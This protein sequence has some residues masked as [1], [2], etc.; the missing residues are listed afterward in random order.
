VPTDSVEL[1]ATYLFLQARQAHHAPIWLSTSSDGGLAW[2]RNGGSAPHHR[3]IFRCDG[4]RWSEA[5]S[6]RSLLDRLSVLLTVPWQR[7][8]VYMEAR[9]AI[10]AIRRGD[11]VYMD[12][13]Y[14]GALV[15]YAGGPPALL[16]QMAGEALE[17]GGRVVVSDSRPLDLPGWSHQDITDWFHKGKRQGREL[18]SYACGQWDHDRTTTMAGARGMDGR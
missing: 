15:R 18:L 7:F 10:Q 1:A 12:P 5:L 9:E 4:G 13:P 3:A 8:E 11:I 6:R 17:R 2:V 14:Q 16:P